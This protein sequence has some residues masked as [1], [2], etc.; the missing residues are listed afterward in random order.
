MRTATLVIDAVLGTGVEGAAKGKA[1]ELIEAINEHFPLADVVAVD[2]PSGVAA[3]RASAGEA[4]RAKHTVTFTAPKPCLVL[5][6]ACELAGK[7]HVAPIGTPPELY[8]ERP[9]DLALAVR[10]GGL[11]ARCSSRVR[12]IRTKACTVTCW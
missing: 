12:A 8:E 10:A 9:G 4:V 6:P 2:V 5:S 11:C 3:I 1:A 7:V